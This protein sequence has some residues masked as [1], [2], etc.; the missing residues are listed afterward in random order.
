MSTSHFAQLA[1]QRSY[2][3]SAFGS[4]AA[5]SSETVYAVKSALVMVGG[6]ERERWAHIAVTRCNGNV[7]WR[8]CRCARSGDHIATDERGSTSEA[9]SGVILFLQAIEETSA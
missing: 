1:R 7:G 4:S 5:G 6:T 9:W 3:G 2:V 8:D